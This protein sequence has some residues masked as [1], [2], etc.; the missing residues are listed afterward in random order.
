MCLDP[1]P[2]SVWIQHFQSVRSICWHLAALHFL[3]HICHEGAF[4]DEMRWDEEDVW[5]L[6]LFVSLLFTQDLFIRWYALC[7]PSA[8]IRFTQ[9]TLSLQSA[10]VDKM[11]RSISPLK[12]CWGGSRSPRGRYQVTYHNEW[13]VVYVVSAASL[14]PLNSPPSQT[15]LGFQRIM[16]ATF[17]YGTN[18]MGLISCNCL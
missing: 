7:D 2:S 11:T 8:P 4:M 17:K 5:P 1:S 14:S 12:A 16:D 15:E 9:G 13:G 10:K 6:T 3:W 18:Y